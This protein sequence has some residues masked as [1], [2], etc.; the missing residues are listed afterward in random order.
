MNVDHEQVDCDRQAYT[1]ALEYLTVVCNVPRELI[2]RHINPTGERA[3]T[4][5]AV[6]EK[7]L[8]SAQSAGMGPTVIGASIGGVS[9]LG[10]ML[11][12]FD[13]KLVAQ[14]YADAWK[15]VFED[16]K[17]ELQPRGRLRMEPG[18][19]WPLF[20]R[21]IISGA[22]FLSEF[23]T[24]EDFYRWADTFYDND[25]TR[26]SLP[27]M[28]AKAIDGFGFALACAFLKELGYTRYAKPD[29]HL[30][31]I[32]TALGLSRSQDDF[33]VHDAIV[34][35]ADN[36]GVTPYNVDMLFWLVASGD[37]YLDDIKI[38]RQREKFI[39]YAG[40]RLNCPPVS[41]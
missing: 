20:C 39:A 5:N 22:R 28:L 24:A 15:P 26:K 6:Y 41:L 33:D 18:S 7:L 29:T 17:R 3:K 16:I 32:F 34:R 36:A 12:D 8:Q 31:A 40:P 21:S 37:F 4:L 23:D 27:L 2:E 1:L 25:G 14:K 30:K 13:P 19:R 9:N 10:K 11:F 35:V 38:G